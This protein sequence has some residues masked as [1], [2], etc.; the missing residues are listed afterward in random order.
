MKMRAIRRALRLQVS[1]TPLHGRGCLLKYCLFRYGSCL[2]QIIYCLTYVSTETL[3][4]TLFMYFAHYLNHQTLM[5]VMGVR[6]PNRQLFL[7]SLVWMYYK[8]CTKNCL[9]SHL[10][11]VVFHFHNIKCNFSQLPRSLSQI[12]SQVALIRLLSLCQE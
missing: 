1:I 11:R 6:D 8:P 4:Q 12:I 2:G 9:H 3:I 5:M 7:A 10:H